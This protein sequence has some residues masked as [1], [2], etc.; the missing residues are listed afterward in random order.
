[1][2]ADRL[3]VREAAGRFEIMDGSRLVLS[4]GSIVD[5]CAAVRGLGARLWLDWGRTVING[6]PIAHD[7]SPT[8]L[9]SASVGRVRGEQHGPGAGRWFWSISTNDK[10]WRKHG[11]QR[12]SE[13]SKDEAVA[14]LEREFTA[15]IADTYKYL[16]PG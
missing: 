11:G 1:M 15:Y 12:G 9:G 2:P 6:N 14:A 5:A 13:A 7:F 16:P 10:R 4:C 3:K 8:F